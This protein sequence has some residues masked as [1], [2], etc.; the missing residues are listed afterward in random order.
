MRPHKWIVSQRPASLSA[1]VNYTV[2]LKKVGVFEKWN[3][4][5]CFYKRGFSL[6]NFFFFFG[7][8]ARVVTGNIDLCGQTNSIQ[9]KTLNHSV[10]LRMCVTQKM[11]STAWTESGCVAVRLKSSL[12][13]VTEKV[14]P[15]LLARFSKCKY[16]QLI[17]LCRCGHLNGKRALP[18]VFSWILKVSAYICQLF[19]QSTK[20]DEVKGKALSGQIISLW[21]LRPRQSAQALAQ[22]QL[23]EIPIP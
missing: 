22:P 23:R 12:P 2:L 7:G 10:Y 4:K 21:R 19:S 17:T 18:P 9:A 11:P 14:S 1:H 8:G 3:G 20:S 6:D 5:D 16:T 13:R 15:Q